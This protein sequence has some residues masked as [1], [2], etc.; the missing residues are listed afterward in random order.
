MRLMRL[1]PI[2]SPAVAALVLTALLGGCRRPAAGPPEP[3]A[4]P[5]SV[6]ILYPA[7]PG[8]FVK[9]VERLRP[10]VVSLVAATPV[11][12]GP[13]DWFP[14]GGPG[15]GGPSGEL[16]ERLRRSLGSGFIV[17]EAGIIV[18]N[19]H[20]LGKDRDLRVRLDG[21][22]EVVAKVVGEDAAS[23]LAVLSIQPPPGTRLVKMRFGVSNELQV[24]EW[25][26]A[27]GNPFGLGVTLSVGVVS[28]RPAQDLP[29]G[30]AGYHAFIQTD[31][32]IHPG[33]SGGPLCNTAGQVIGVSTAVSAETGRIG[34]AVPAALAQK[35][36][37]A[38]RRDGRVVRAWLGMYVDRVTPEAAT[39]AGLKPPRGALVSSVLANRPA[40]RAGLRAGDII[41]GFDSQEVRDA[42][43]LRSRASLAG[44]NRVVALKVWRD[45]KVLHFSPLTEP[46]PD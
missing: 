33:N 38:L 41:L 6:K 39:R 12:G 13:A 16:G 29:R 11:R 5:P 15:E 20:L 42:D 18:T 28:A 32:A 25:V 17:D 2:R 24:G 37:P 44:V 31:A 19:A 14:A 40:E 35:I 1:T 34:F 8:G 27:L 9:L 21:G 22:A 3:G 46:M 10:S 43:D 23:D 36:V 45:H 4:A 30:E 26:A 7:A